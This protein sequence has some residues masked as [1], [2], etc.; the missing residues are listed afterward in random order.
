V[1]RPPLTAVAGEA[2]AAFPDRDGAP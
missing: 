1:A 2:V